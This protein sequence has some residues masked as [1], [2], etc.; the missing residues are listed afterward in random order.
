VKPDTAVQI[1]FRPFEI[2]TIRFDKDG[3]WKE[4]RMIG[5]EPGG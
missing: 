2:K 3:T 1:V 5:E 4:V